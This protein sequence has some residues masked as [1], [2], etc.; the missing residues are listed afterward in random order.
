MPKTSRFFQSGPKLHGQ[1]YNP[2]MLKGCLWKTSF[3][4]PRLYTVSQI[5][6]TRNFEMIL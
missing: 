5:E 2:R 6:I 4:K 1:E 3:K